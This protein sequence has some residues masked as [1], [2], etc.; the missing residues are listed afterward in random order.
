MVRFI[1]WCPTAK[2]LISAYFLIQQLEQLSGCQKCCISLCSKVFINHFYQMKAS[3][4]CVNILIYW[5]KYWG[6]RSVSHMASQDHFSVSSCHKIW[7]WFTW[8]NTQQALHVCSFKQIFYLNV[9]IKQIPIHF[10]PSPNEPEKI[11]WSL[12][13]FYLTNWCLVM[14]ECVHDL[15]HYWFR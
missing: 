15:G 10:L 14:H 5:S 11:C 2:M 8:K 12:L 1:L 13:K 7:I 3:P 4:D 9:M 6:D